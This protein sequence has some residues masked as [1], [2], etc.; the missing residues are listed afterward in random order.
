[1]TG[2]SGAPLPVLMRPGEVISLKEAVYRTGKSEK[3]LRRWCKEA[4]IGRRSGRSARWEISVLALE[5]KQYGDEGALEDMRQ[6]LFGSTRV[7]RYS[8]ILGLTS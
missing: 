5:A 2:P 6:G 1:M 8:R 4:G 7:A 3:T